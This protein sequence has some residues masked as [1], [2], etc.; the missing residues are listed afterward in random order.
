MSDI[1]PVGAPP[2][3]PAVRRRN[4]LTAWLTRPKT[5]SGGL[6]VALTVWFM[7]ANNAHT[8]IHFWVFWVTAQLWTVLAGT[9][10]VGMVL[11]FLMRR[12]TRDRKRRD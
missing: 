11:G 9:F 12:R 8:R 1:P 3:E 6:I 5:V 4:S 7:L 10:V 2:G